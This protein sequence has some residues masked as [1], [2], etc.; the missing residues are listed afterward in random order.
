M[1]GRLLC[2]RAL[3]LLGLGHLLL[4]GL[5]LLCLLGCR[6]GLSG[7]EL[8]SHRRRR[9]LGRRWRRGRWILGGWR[10]LWRRRRLVLRRRLGAVQFGQAKGHRCIAQQ[11]W[12]RQ[13]AVSAVALA[14]RGGTELCGSARLAVW[15][16]KQ[17]R[18]GRV[19]RAQACH[20]TALFDTDSSNQAREMWVCELTWRGG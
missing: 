10:R 7:L 13:V 15:Q 20:C 6:L 1:R 11:L 5:G 4:A 18:L 19:P 16:G 12:P 9:R 17:V 8:N 14:C 3:R 2:G